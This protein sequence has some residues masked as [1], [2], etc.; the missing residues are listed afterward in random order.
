MYNN[1]FEILSEYNF[2]YHESIGGGMRVQ[3]L[4]ILMSWRLLPFSGIREN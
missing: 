4:H 3:E 1:F 2:S